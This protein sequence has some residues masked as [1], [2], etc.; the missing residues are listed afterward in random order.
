MNAIEELKKPMY[1]SIHIG[2]QHRSM[3]DPVVDGWFD[4]FFVMAVGYGC[5]TLEN[6]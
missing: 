1:S 2:L 5:G 4:V 3:V 6:Q